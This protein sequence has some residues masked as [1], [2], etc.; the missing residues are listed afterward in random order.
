MA[1]FSKYALALGKV[2][3]KEEVIA[4][5]TVRGCPDPEAPTLHA[6][7]KSAWKRELKSGAQEK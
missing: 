1:K 6:H 7:G 3:G 4:V 5:C 2:E